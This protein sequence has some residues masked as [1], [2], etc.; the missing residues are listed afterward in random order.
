MTNCC[1]YFHL[2]SKSNLFWKHILYAGLLSLGVPGVPDSGRSVT[3]IMPTKYNWH[4]LPTALLW[5]I[6]FDFFFLQLGWKPHNSFWHKGH[7]KAQICGSETDWS[8]LD[9]TRKVHFI[10]E[11]PST[12]AAIKPTTEYG[13]MMSRFHI[14]YGQNSMPESGKLCFFMKKMV[15]FAKSGTR[16]AQWQN[17]SQRRY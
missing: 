12:K 14:L 1:W 8:H 7:S 2:K 6:Y 15:D 11:H 17:M 13:R 3:Q 10:D 9:K 16:E 5:E 4:P